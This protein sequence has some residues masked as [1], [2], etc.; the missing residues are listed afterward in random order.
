MQDI[1]NRSSKHFGN[2]R[3]LSLSLSYALIIHYLS[4]LA[5]KKIS[6]DFHLI[7]DDHPI[8]HTTQSLEAPTIPTRCTNH[9]PVSIRVGNLF[10]FHALATQNLAQRLATHFSTFRFLCYTLLIDV[11]KKKKIEKKKNI[12]WHR[13]CYGTPFALAVVVN[14]CRISTYVKLAAAISS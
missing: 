7:V 12:F 1:T 14:H 8:L 13:F 3:H 5:R 9:N 10:Q 6:L 2:Y 11:C 4:S